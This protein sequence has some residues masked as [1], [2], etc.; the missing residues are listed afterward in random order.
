MKRIT[1]ILSLMV[2]MVTTAM[3]QIDVTKTYRIKDVASGE[4]LTAFNHDTHSGGANG[5]VGVA[6]LDENSKEQVFYLEQTSNGYLLR[7]ASGDYYVVG[8]GWNVDA[9]KQNGTIF[10]F[11]DAGEGNVYLKK[12][13][14]YFK[15]QDLSGTKYVFCDAPD[16]A[17]A[18]WVLEVVGESGYATYNT[19][20]ANKAYVIKTRERG[21]LT[22]NA[23]A[24]AFCST[25][26]AGRGKFV[27]HANTDNHFAVVTNG[28]NN[29]LYSVKAKKF[30]KADKSLTE[31]IGDVVAF[32]DAKAEGASRMSIYFKDVENANI[33]IGGDN[34]AQVNWWSAVDHGNAML[35]IEV[36]DFDPTEAL[37][38]F[39]KVATITYE[40]QLNGK[41]L[42]IQEAT[43][44]KGEAYPE[45][46]VPEL[47]LGVVVT[48][49]KPAGNVTAN[50]TVQIALGVDN[51]KVPFTFVT[52]GT[53]TKWYYAQMHAY[54]GYHWFVAPAAD[55]ASVETQDHKFAADETDAHLWG[56][57]GTVEGGFKMVNK[58][59]KEAIK[60]NNDGVAAMASVADATAFTV[61][62]SPTNGWFCLRHPEGNYLNSQG[63]ARLDDFVIKH[64][65]DND[66]G[67]SFFLTEYVDEDVTVNV[68]NAGWATNY[69][70]E[71]VHVPAGVN[72]YII[73]GAAD[74]YVT[75]E[76]IAEGEVIPANTGI[77]LE[78]AG[79]YNFAK[80]VSY[81]YTLADNLLNGSVED[82]YVEGTAYVLANHTEAGLGFYK[83][84]LNM[85]ADG[86]KVGVETGTHFL[87]NAG[88]AYLVLPAASETV[89]FYGLD[90]DGTTGVENVEV[91]S[92]VKVIYDLTGRR[93]EAITA[94][95]IYI[96]NGVKRVVR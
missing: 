21:G 84:E 80:T 64:W 9:I 66:N 20:N 94:P 17:R 44:T 79:E 16:S 14:T 36:A 55:G 54:G 15:I 53:P 65:N 40:Y 10:N 46:I 87:N 29:Y 74:G 6:A 59:T 85:D 7:L 30:L 75:K 5:G 35:F 76:Q 57:V 39:N 24:T 12:G 78:N 58:A 47:P 62:P 13:S 67:S 27:E 28:E 33:N 68:S 73:T 22:I 25:N 70:A 18:T 2:A 83:A 41:T 89:A 90:W 26:D 96:V 91:E 60:S 61:M 69:F 4:Y 3:A 63:S 56:F 86:N 88:K 95:G 82:T 72:A 32:R 92:E 37:E 48:G 1:L 45:L 31:G 71:S 81:N 8:W 52:E 19:F 77:L 49:A 43:A 42:A 93:V 38:V 11:E 51:S 34:E 50:A 23:D